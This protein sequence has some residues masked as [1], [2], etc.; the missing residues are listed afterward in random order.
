MQKQRH[1]GLRAVLAA[2][3]IAAI[4]AGGGAAPAFADE[5]SS[6][7]VQ[8]PA[9]ADVLRV[10]TSGY[11]D[12]FNPFLSVYLLPTNINRY[13]Y[14]N[15]VQY[16]AETGAPTQGLA[17]KWTTSDDGLVWTFTLHSGLKWSD[18]EPLTA[19]DVKWTYEQMMTDETMATANGSLVENFA[20]VT[21]P[22]DTTVVITLKQAQAPNPG[23]EIPV[24]PEHVWSKIS[25]PADFANDSDVVGSGPF[26]LS[27]YSANQSISLKANPYF[28]RGA[29]KLSGIDYIYYTNSDA[30]VQALKAGEV[31]IVTGLTSTQLN[32]LKG[33]EGIT[34]NVGQ[35]RRFTSLQLNYGSITPEGKSYGTGNAALK[36]KSVREAI[37]YAID[38]PTLMNQVLEGYGTVATS[39]IPAAFTEWALPSDDTVIQSYSEDKAKEVLASD[40]WT[41]GSDGVMAK[42]GETLSLRL[43]VDADDPQQQSMSDY[44]V[45]WLKKVGIDVTVEST[46]SDTI[47]DK[48]AS[49]DYDLVFGGW[50]VNPD[51]DYQLSIN[52]CSSRP[53][54]DG[55]G[56]VTQDGYCN[57]EFDTLYAQQ[58]TELD[59]AKREA[60]VKKMLELHYADVAQITLWYANQLEAYRS[61]RFTGFTTQ[62]SSNGMI[63]NQ[64]GYWG[65]YTAEPVSEST[66]SSGPA[67]GLWIALG[68]VVVI[69]AVVVIVL[70][71]RR[72]KGADTRE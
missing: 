19:S 36:D 24:V 28:W 31:D 4:T 53:E 48:T 71:V 10:A 39:F 21:A 64:A 13:V 50:S 6:A 22:D 69:A 23:V 8:A 40:G 42:D 55:S 7:S 63:M 16:D 43:L 27:S 41:A 25:D 66:A 47:S 15:L 14:E 72:K 49:G 70:T 62:P 54:A 56:A 58:H 9:S 61:D 12:T 67:A 35:G 60:I 5:S 57:E 33:V 65:F 38:V 52:L 30:Q 3:M 17:E 18:G 51:P 34:T 68:A 44:I 46:D 11:V 2:A 29:P 1:R 37:R 32:A 45:P 59:Q 26:V 20:S